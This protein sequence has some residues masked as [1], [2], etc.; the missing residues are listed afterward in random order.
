MVVNTR[1]TFKYN[2]NKLKGGVKLAQQLHEMVDKAPIALSKLPSQ[3]GLSFITCIEVS[4][5]VV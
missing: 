4:I 2:A 5:Y 1:L 3:A